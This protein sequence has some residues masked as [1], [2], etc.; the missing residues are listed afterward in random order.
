LA[1]ATALILNGVT[2]LEEHFLAAK[3]GPQ[4]TTYAAQVGRYIP[5]SFCWPTESIAPLNHE[6]AMRTFVQ[7]SFFLLGVPVAAFAQWGQ[8]SGYLPIL[9]LVP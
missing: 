3:F 5:R 9:L 6:V 2:R 4:Y 1:L 8:L 7:S